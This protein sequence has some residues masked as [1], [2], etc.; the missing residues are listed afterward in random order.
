MSYNRGVFS[1]R[2]LRDAERH[3]L[4]ALREDLARQGKDLFDLT[5]SNPTHAGLPYEREAIL[6]ALADVGS[7]A[8]E[9]APFGIAKTRATISAIYAARGQ[10][11]DPNHIVLTASTSEAY[12]HVFR[13][14]CD[15]GDE[16]LVPAPSYPLFDELARAESIV[17]R[18]YPLRYDGAWH[19]TK[20]DL[21]HARTPRTRAVLVVHPNNP[22]GSYLKKSENEAIAA[23]GLPCI[24]DAVFETYA[25][26]L[27][28]DVADPMNEGPRLR[29]VLSGLSKL[30]ALPQMKL[31]WTCVR[32]DAALVSESL[33]RLEHSLDATLSVGA[34][35]Q[36]AAASLVAWTRSTHDA[37]LARAK[38]NLA[39]A[40]TALAGTAATA[41]HVEG[42]WYVIV[43]L[44]ET[45][46]EEAWALSLLEAQGVYT[47]PGEFFGFGSG[48]HLILSLL[49]PEDH[50]AEGIARLT[51]HVA[52]TI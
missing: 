33:A 16:I 30:A 31:A 39:G 40:K 51:K 29:F 41:L 25:I 22:T 49:T 23:L 15:P 26:D 46:T 50:F 35:V 34:P 27:P 38:T 12:A 47:H 52:G 45:R 10:A 28:R 3:P 6:N 13:L 44:P 21:E 4:H 42:G 5:E 19:L 43:R 14:L 8:Y 7:L 17:L 24:Y 48:A 18:P 36:H 1:A 37:I 9:P 2:S 32:G 20:D 11:I